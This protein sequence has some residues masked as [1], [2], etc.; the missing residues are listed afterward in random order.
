M[1]FCCLLIFFQNQYFRRI[2]SECPDQAG[3]FY[4]PGIGPN[5]LHR[6]SADDISRQIINTQEDH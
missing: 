3:C 6:L 5:C 2:P 1:L 4:G